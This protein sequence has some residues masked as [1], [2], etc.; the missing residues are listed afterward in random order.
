MASPIPEAGVPITADIV[1]QAL[2]QAEK[3]YK[4]R[5]LAPEFMSLAEIQENV[6]VLAVVLNFQTKLSGGPVSRHLKMFG[7][8][9]ADFQHT[10]HIVIHS[11]KD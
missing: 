7:T 10:L 8:A 6:V 5:G 1:R 11:E 3:E 9:V 2:A 4:Q